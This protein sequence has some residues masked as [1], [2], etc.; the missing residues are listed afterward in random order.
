MTVRLG[1]QAGL[2]AFCFLSKTTSLEIMLRD[3]WKGKYNNDDNFDY[4]SGSVDRRRGAGRL[5][6]QAVFNEFLA[7]Q[8]R[9]FFSM[10][11]SRSRVKSR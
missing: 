4:C 9:G 6:I 11:E 7:Q 1:A 5:K 10:A 3:I 8:H 2:A